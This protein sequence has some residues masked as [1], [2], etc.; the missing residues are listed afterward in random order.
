M[1]FSLHSATNEMF[2][3]PRFLPE[4]KAAYFMN[5]RPFYYKTMTKVPIPIKIVPW[6]D[7]ALTCSCRNPKAMTMVN[8]TLSLSIGTALDTSP[9]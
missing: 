1:R 5:R 2:Y 9:S 4:K 8:T 6:M 3:Q 7:L